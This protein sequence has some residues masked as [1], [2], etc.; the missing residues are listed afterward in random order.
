MLRSYLRIDLFDS[1]G[2]SLIDSIDLE[3]G[4]NINEL[5]GDISNIGRYAQLKV[6]NVIDGEIKENSLSSFK[7][8]KL[9]SKNRYQWILSD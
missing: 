5:L 1:I 4:E 2:G 8:I 7:R 6:I 9:K 3:S